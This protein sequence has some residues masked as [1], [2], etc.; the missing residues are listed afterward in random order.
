GRRNCRVWW[1]KDMAFRPVVNCN[2]LFGWFFASSGSS[3]DVVVAFGFSEIELASLNRGGFRLEEILQRINEPMPAL[4]HD[5]CA[6]ALL[7]QCTADFTGNLE[8]DR[9]QNGE[10]I[11]ATTT[12]TQDLHTPVSSSERW[13]C[14]CQKHDEIVRQSRLIAPG[15]FWIKLAIGHFVEADRRGPVF[16]KLDHLHFNNE[17]ESHLDLH[18]I[19]YDVPTFG[20]HHYS[21][22][23]RSFPNRR[24]S[25]CKKPE[26]FQ[27]LHIRPAE[28]DLEAVVQ[29]VNCVNAARVLFCWPQH[30]EKFGLLF[31]IALKFSIFCWKAMS[32]SIASLSTLIYTIL[33]FSHTIFGCLSRLHIDKIV[34]KVIANA[35]KNIYFRCCQFLHWPIFLQGQTVREHSCV[36]QA[37]KAEFKKHSIW[38]SL[39]VDILLGNMFGFPL[40]I[41][42]EPVCSYVSKFS[43]GFTDDW[44]RAGCVWLM[45]NPAGFKLN[46][47]LAGVLGMISLNAIQI[48]STLVAFMASLFVPA[49]KGLALCGMFFGLTSAFS[50]ALDVISLLTVHVLTLELFLS[51]VYS[52]QIQALAALWRIFRGRKWNPLRCRFDSY[53]YTVEEHV[54]GSL[55]FTPILLLLPTTSAFYVFFTIL[56]T[57]LIFIYAVVDAAISILH[58]TPYAEIFLWLKRRQRFPSGIW[59]DVLSSQ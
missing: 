4:L 2:Y 25:P 55:L 10:T 31:K 42:A 17:M 9:F 24:L 32:L 14:G 21:L 36:E 44:L 39:V 43:H 56:H 15:K 54:V 6:F 59:F 22:V 26:W 45:G 1:P 33:Q 50:L 3:L 49:V 27:S 58:S 41:T 20:G 12:R 52:A 11:S 16:P 30:A 35:S 23:D 37:E 40:W 57:S 19:S 8:F 28:S 18:V 13:S 34:A 7:G 53:D 51:L 38:S 48:W 47:E 5:K 46:T 29:A